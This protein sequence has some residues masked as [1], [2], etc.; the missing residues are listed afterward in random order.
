MNKRRSA[1]IAA[2]VTAAAL[3]LGVAA[4]AA[5]AAQAATTSGQAARTSAWLAGGELPLASTF[6]WKAQPDTQW[7]TKGS[8]QWLY[9]C[10]TGN[11]TKELNTSSVS[12]MQ[13]STTS[14]Q[15]QASQ[16]LFHF[17]DATVAKK[18]MAAIERDYAGCAKDFNH[19]RWLD[20]SSGK[21]LHWTVTRTATRADG[22]AYRV[23]GRDTAGKPADTPDLSSDAQELF[24]QHGKTI[25]MIS[26]D[27]LNG[28]ID[29]AAGAASTLRAMSYRLSHA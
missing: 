10:G 22:V 6:H 26:L 5:P 14:K 15:A 24:V 12:A 13:F 29:N 4:V 28:K 19:R 25:S 1:R 23:V 11:P 3:A 20:I 17:S 9:T 16:V 2:S 18:A 7:T 21:P 27:A 8:F